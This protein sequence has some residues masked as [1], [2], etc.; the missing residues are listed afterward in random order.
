MGVWQ[1]ERGRTR[2]KPAGLERFGQAPYPDFLPPY[3]QLLID[4]DG[5]LWV[6][7][8]RTDRTHDSRWK[9]FSRE[10]GFLGT[11]I[12]PSGFDL[13]QVGRDFVLGR[14]LDELGVEHMRSYRLTRG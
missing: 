6:T 7:D 11:L 8:F 3:E 2:V 14:W 13:Y 4:A 12:M 9:I 1:R 5:N 10:G